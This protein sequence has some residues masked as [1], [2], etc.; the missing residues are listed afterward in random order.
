MAVEDF[1]YQELPGGARIV[2]GSLFNPTDEPIANAQIQVSL[3]DETNTR[4]GQMIIPVQR[5]PANGHK[6]FREAVRSDQD[7][8]SVKPRSVLVP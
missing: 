5:I 2:T 8:R 4:I 3:Y 1:E 7:V 6:E